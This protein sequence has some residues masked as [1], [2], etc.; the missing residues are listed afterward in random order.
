VPRRTRPRPEPRSESSESGAEGVRLSITTQVGD[1]TFTYYANH[2]EIACI[3]HEFAILFSRV[4]TKLPPEKLEEARAGNLTLTCDVQIL[5]APTLINGLIRA[6]TTQKA[7]YEE[8]YG[9]IHEPR[10]TDAENSDQ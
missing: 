7:T 1:D 9:T 6:L 8:R 4:P 3:P 2:A 5:I 10:G